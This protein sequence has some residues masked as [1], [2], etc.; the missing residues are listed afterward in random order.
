MAVALVAD[1]DA[2]Q[3]DWKSEK[4]RQCKLVK[5]HAPIDKT[6]HGHLTVIRTP[7][8]EKKSL[9][10]VLNG[11]L[12]KAK[13]AAG[14]KVTKQSGRSLGPRDTEQREIDKDAKD[15][16]AEWSKTKPKHFDNWPKIQYE[17]PANAVDTVLEYLRATVNNGGPCPGMSFR[18]RKGT[19]DSGD[20]LITWGIGNPPKEK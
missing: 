6:P 19:A 12:K 10:Q 17:V 15:I 16:F 11:K 3:C 1:N 14:V 5:D 20:V 9:S 18:Y 7:A 4:G 8:S 13:V 2:I